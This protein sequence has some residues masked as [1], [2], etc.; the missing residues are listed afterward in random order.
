MRA[1]HT[2]SIDDAV[3]VLNKENCVAKQLLHKNQTNM[4]YAVAKLWC[5]CV[6][7]AYGLDRKCT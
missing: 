7:C 4:K 5:D 2:H 3:R 6:V 1:E